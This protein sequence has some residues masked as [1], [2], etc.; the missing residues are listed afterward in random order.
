MMNKRN[1]INIVIFVF[2]LNFILS[3]CISKPSETIGAPQNISTEN[4][5]NINGDNTEVNLELM[6]E[7]IKPKVRVKSIALSFVPEGMALSYP[8]Y[9]SQDIIEKDIDGD[10]ESEIIFTYRSINGDSVE[11]IYGITILKRNKNK[12][13]KIYEDYGG[14]KGLYR[15]D[16]ADIDGDKKNEILISSSCG[17]DNLNIERKV[18]NVYKWDNGLKLLCETEINYEQMH[19]YDMPDK[20]GNKNGKAELALWNF[21]FQVDM[22]NFNNWDSV[23]LVRDLF[24]E[25]VGDWDGIHDIYK[26]KYGCTVEVLRY[27]DKAGGVVFA[28]DCYPHYY[29]KVEDYFKGVI[30][31]NLEKKENIHP[32]IWYYLAD[33]QLK[34]EKYEAA[35]ESINKAYKL[36]KEDIYGQ[37]NFNKAFDVLKAEIFN[38]LKQNE[39]A[40]DTLI[41]VLKDVELK[42]EEIAANIKDGKIEE[43]TDLIDTFIT[44]KNYCDK[45]RIY[46]DLGE[47]YSGMNDKEN[48]KLYYNK[49]LKEWSKKFKDSAVSG[50][51]YKYKI[52]MSL[53]NVK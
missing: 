44:I 14:F 9:G 30:N 46:Y 51:R 49:A 39:K 33:A 40:V 7:N 19:I 10:G 21:D 48:A 2:S 16:C 35:L 41:N 29:K 34:E 20:D 36:L 28:E 43:R 8:I 42:E 25:E 13:R 17:L 31:I 38:K 26:F 1:L 15:I 11:W 52:N 23:K 24:I 27:D 3:G 4:V 12:W 53:E 18:L 45:M 22:G 47:S 50:I 6:D 32:M 37:D 5:E